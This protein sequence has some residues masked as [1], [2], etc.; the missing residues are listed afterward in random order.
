MQEVKY[1]TK[2]NDYDTEHDYYWYAANVN[3]KK[4]PG[5]GGVYRSINLDTYRY[6]SNS[7]IEIVDPEGTDDK[8]IYITDMESNNK[9]IAPMYVEGGAKID[10]T[11]IAKA[12]Q[13][14]QKRTIKA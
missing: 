1:F 12:Q 10:I 2:P 11:K 4:I 8:K 3:L 5:I 9:V 7:P 6:C 13:N 14:Q